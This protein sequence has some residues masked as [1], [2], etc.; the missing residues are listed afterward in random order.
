MHFPASLIVLRDML[1]GL[2]VPARQTKMKSV[3]SNQGSA[4][5]G[6]HWNDLYFNILHCF[7]MRLTEGKKRRD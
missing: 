1:E 7:C 5:T 3:L 2:A 6:Q 4:E